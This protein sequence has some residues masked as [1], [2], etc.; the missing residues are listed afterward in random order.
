MQNLLIIVRV[1]LLIVSFYGYFQIFRKKTGIKTEFAFLIVFSAVGCVMY[2]A[3]ILNILKEA[4]ALVLLAGLFCALWSVR[5]RISVKNIVTPGTVFFGVMAVFL[6]FLLYGSEYTR[7]D[8]FSHWALIVKVMLTNNRLPNFQDSI[9]SFQSYPPGSA[10]FIYYIVKISGI[11]AEWASMYAQALYIL[12]SVTALFAF[13]KKKNIIGLSVTAAAAVFLMSGNI[14]F[15]DLL[16][17]T[18]LPAVG[19]GAIAFCIYYKESLTKKI[20]T[21]VPVLVM[22][23]AIK[24]SGIF[25]VA[26]IG[27]YYLFYMERNCR[28]LKGLAALAA[29]PFLS[30][31]LWKKHVALVFENGLSSKHTMSLQ[32]YKNILGIKSAEDIKNIASQMADRVFSLSNQ[33]LWGLLFL[34]LLLIFVRIFQKHKFAELCR[35]SVLTVG[36]YFFY[37]AGTLAMYLFSMPDNE[38]LDLASYDRYHSTILIFA[39]GILCIMVITITNEALGRQRRYT[40]QAAAG[41]LCAA[42][43]YVSVKPQPDF[44]ARQQLEGT[45]RAK[46]DEILANYEIPEQSSYLILCK[47]SDGFLYYLGTYLFN[48]D[49]VAV[50]DEQSL[51]EIGNDWEDYEY[52]ILYEETSK[53]REY[54]DKNFLTDGEKVIHLPSLMAGQ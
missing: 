30:S 11:R 6:L 4:A 23:C 28:G 38:A 26:I 32:N 25:F 49:R 34:L 35:L 54:V 27:I 45:R 14:G 10:C 24:N 5:V 29:F 33:A 48:T 15:F 51:E 20:W 7:Y 9:I 50:Y 52:L 53:I 2:L 43:L 13:V 22:L 12:G 21:L 44:Y 3:G 18:L 19:L 39:A 31:F 16:V 46:F 8:N 40:Y 1:L 47:K 42:A 17:D 37:Q 36:S 41:I